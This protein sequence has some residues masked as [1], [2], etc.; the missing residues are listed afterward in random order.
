GATAAICLS[1][2]YCLRPRCFLRFTLPTLSGLRLSTGS[3][4]RSHSC[5]CFNLG[6]FTFQFAPSYNGYRNSIGTTAGRLTRSPPRRTYA[7][8][9]LVL[10]NCGGCAGGDAI[11]RTAD[12]AKRD[13]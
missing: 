3:F 13:R 6:F 11:A 5:L 12:P 2:R 8:P 10:A 1:S 9:S 7:S 4:F